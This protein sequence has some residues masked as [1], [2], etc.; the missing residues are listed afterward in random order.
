MKKTLTR[1]LVIITVIGLAL[2]ACDDGRKPSSGGGGTGCTHTWGNDV[3]TPPTCETAGYTTQTCSVCSET[4]KINPTAATGH[5]W[6]WLITT[7]PTDTDDGEETRTCSLCDEFE[8]KPLT[9][10][11]FK[12]YFYGT[13]E[14]P[15]NRI[16][17]I[18]ETKFIYDAPDFYNMYFEIDYLPVTVIENTNNATKDDFPIGLMFKGTI[19]N[20]SSTWT[21]SET[22]I[23]ITNHE[24][25]SNVSLM[26][27]GGTLAQILYLNVDKGSISNNGNVGNNIFT[28]QEGGQ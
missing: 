12:T 24:T 18:T 21:S 1:I 13:W 28:K 10:A 19:S 26:S 4:Q 23:V 11:T 9:F 25:G 27:D 8:K 15:N 16:R 5:T 6:Q 2:T 3:V 22:A 14:S 7:F 20:L 17:E